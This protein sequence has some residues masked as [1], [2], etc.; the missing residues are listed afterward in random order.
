VTNISPVRALTGL[1]SLSC[2]LVNAAVKGKL[3]DLSPLQGMK[4]NWLACRNN[5]VSDLSPLRGMP[6]TKLTCCESQVA[7]LSPLRGM[8][9]THLNCG[10]TQ[11]AD[12]SPLQGM[13]L[14]SLHVL[15]T[16]VSDLSSVVGMH[17]KYLAC[18]NTK[19]SKLTPLEGMPLTFMSCNNTQVSDLSPLKEMNLTDV[20]IT[21]QNITKG[22][23]VIRQ[24]KSVKVI[25]LSTSQYWPV[26]EFWK[27]YDAG[28][29]GK[30]AAPA[31]LAYLDPAFQQ[32]V[33]DTQAL[34]AE[35]QVEAVSKKLT[36]LNP[37]FDGKTGSYAWQ[38]PPKIENG[39]V[40]ELGF[41]SDNV[42][43]ISPVRVLGGLK[44]LRCRGHGPGKG[45][46][47]DLSCL[48]GMALA[49][50]DCGFSQ[51]SDLSPLHGMPLTTLEF[52][53]TN[54]SDLSPL[55]GAPL[56]WLNFAG[57]KVADLLP[58][59]PMPLTH[60]FCNE[61]QV[62]D[63]SPV[64]G[65]RLTFIY[66]ANSQ[67]ADLSPLKGM[68]LTTIWCEHTQ[69]SDLMPLEDCKSLTSLNVKSTKATPASIAALQKALSNC[70][71]EWDG[72]AKHITNINDP[73]FQQWMQT[74]ATLTA[75]KQIEAVSKKLMELN[76]GFD[77]KLTG[78]AGNGTPKIENGMVTE[79]GY[80]A[81]DVTDIS[82]VR[83]LP[84][85]KVLRCVGR[86]VG[87]GKLSDLSPLQGIKL[88]ALNCGTSNVSDLSPLQGM[89]LE[90]LECIYTPISSL[91]PLQGMRLTYLNCAATEVTD[92]TPL[93]GMPLTDLIC[94][95]Q[96]LSSLSP[97]QGM[98]FTDLNCS[99]SQVSDL[100]PLESCKSLKTLN[101]R[102]TKV[103]PA[104]TAA[105][106]KALPNCKIEWDGA[107]EAVAGHPN[108]PWETPA[109]QHWVKATQAVPAEKQI[110]AVSKKLM[111]LNPGFDG[112][113]TVTDRKGPPKIRSGVIT[114][115]AFSTDNVTDI[116][117][118]RALPGL[119]ELN[120][121]GSRT[122][123]GSS[124]GKLSDLSPLKGMKL[125]RLECYDTKVS[126]LSP[127]QG[128]PLA[129]LMCN[130][131]Q[132]SD[133]SPLRGMPLTYV[134]IGSTLV[135][136]LSPLQGMPL[137]TLRLNHTQV[138]DLSPLKG[139]KLAN[140]NCGVTPLSDL[141]PLR[142]MPLTELLCGSTKITDILPL[143]DC[144]G[145]KTLQ[146]TKTKV[147]PAQV[148]ILQKALP[149][150][151]IEWDDPAKPK[152]PGPVASGTK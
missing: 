115:L 86:I 90:S 89:P 62:S 142:G 10:Y 143:E 29:F 28:E 36:E 109:F 140:I 110:E 23:D 71:I 95:N 9:L 42:K 35:K 3:S 6:L 17:L 13:P 137:T 149:N 22:M 81:D 30:P 124:N 67:I 76:P 145:L 108:Q 18:H 128:M 59:Q 120:C 100:S 87:K 55:Q 4:L 103:T 132:V 46:L 117:P 26:A 12:L 54:V 43:D 80:V 19:V 60:L 152:T 94:G 150:C 102:A 20:W 148:A 7:D 126:D 136:D 116:S 147:T 5:P 72:S 85:L 98:S 112:K 92:L 113:V 15:F 106:Q 104:A 123:G 118:I 52:N 97:L 14:E 141:S 114:E 51:V 111:E 84:G 82:P 93:K 24:L 61:T 49:K 1:K 45:D 63:L 40:A 133:L 134:L 50:L 83:A 37:G 151:K 96:K 122:T 130:Q 34:P 135:S 56:T 129:Y 21:P 107:A 25:G 131:T 44:N 138:S 121:S 119:K 77:G 53:S 57:T 39:V 64:K 144:K 69:V 8:L 125:T 58:L 16:Q 101:V 48:K 68:P 88:K 38:G 79:F 78:S 47:A 91:S 127:L 146:A 65:M 74:V 27:K 139:M 2:G 99:H 32:W 11:V 31:K 73:A 75:A 70:K 66:C 105:L 33:K 41:V